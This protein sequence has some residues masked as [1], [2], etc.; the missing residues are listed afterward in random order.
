M[1]QYRDKVAFAMSTWRIVKEFQT[2]LRELEKRLPMPEV[3]DYLV[4]GIREEYVPGDIYDEIDALKELRAKGIRQEMKY[5]DAQARAAGLT[6]SEPV[7]QGYDLMAIP[8]LE[9]LEKVPS[10]GV[11]R[12][13]MWLGER[14]GDTKL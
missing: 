9:V 4:S 12:Q 8:P 14:E 1:E 13:F 6:L 5:A 2:R 7:R 3:R 10:L 11:Y